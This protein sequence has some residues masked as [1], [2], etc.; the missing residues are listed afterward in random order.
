MVHLAAS[1]GHCTAPRGPFSAVVGAA[2]SCGIQFLS[3]VRCRDSGAAGESLLFRSSSFRWFRS[4]AAT[5]RPAGKRKA[6]CIELSDDE[7]ATKAHGPAKV[8]DKDGCEIKEGDVISDVDMPRHGVGTVVSLSVPGRWDVKIRWHS[9]SGPP[10]RP[11][12]S[13]RNLTA[14]F[15]R[16]TRQAEVSC[17]QVKEAAKQI[18]S[19]FSAGVCSSCLKCPQP[20]PHP[21]HSH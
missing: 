7:D 14:H 17:E 18:I 8:F 2:W 6:G 16:L 12:D 21:N 11:G 15:D 1:S 20:T 3:H 4:G 10:S 19:E 13:L 5:A 9:V